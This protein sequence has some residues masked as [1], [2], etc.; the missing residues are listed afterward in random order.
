MHGSDGLSGSYCG[1]RVYEN[2]R[3]SR[4]APDSKASFCIAHK[5]FQAL[6]VTVVQG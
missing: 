6:P 2:Q 5:V 4:V 3:A 1:P